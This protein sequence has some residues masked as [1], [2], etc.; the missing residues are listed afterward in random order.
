MEFRGF[1]AKFANIGRYAVYNESEWLGIDGIVAKAVSSERN[2]DTGLIHVV[3]EQV[4]EPKGG[5]MPDM[6][7]AAGSENE[8]RPLKWYEVDFEGKPMKKGLVYGRREDGKFYPLSREEHPESYAFFDRLEKEP[9]VEM[10]DGLRAMRNH[11][12]RG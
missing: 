10:T 8:L 5:I 7:F 6:N 1:G 2:A 12:Q 9:P 3:V 4:E 11:M